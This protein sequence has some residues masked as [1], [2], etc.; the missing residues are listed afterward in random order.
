LHR[1]EFGSLTLSS[2][3]SLSR[4]QHLILDVIDNA[5][6]LLGA[7]ASIEHRDR[8]RVRMVVIRRFDAA[9]MS[10][11]VSTDLRSRKVSQLHQHPS[12]ELCIWLGE[13]RISL[14]LLV[15]WSIVQSDPASPSALAVLE[16]FWQRH[17]PASQA[18][19]F[20]SPPGERYR[21]IRR[22]RPQ[23]KR[24]ETFAILLGVIQEIDALQ[25]GRSRHVRW[26]YTR[27]ATG[28]WTK[29]RMNP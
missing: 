16:E 10:I 9:D 28:K 23:R 11:A 1:E 6:P 3:S 8:A 2:I 25:I 22:Q 24:P 14:R 13:R 26:N 15:R 18:I 19:F 27:S 12:S 7:L 29:S 20:M 4:I 21:R 5:P 17:S